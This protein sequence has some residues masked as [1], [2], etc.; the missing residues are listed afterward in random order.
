MTKLRVSRA[1]DKFAKR[2]SSTLK[3]EMWEGIDDNTEHL[4]FFGLYNERDYEV[5]ENFEGKKSIIWGG[6]DIRRAV[7]DYE[8]QRILKNN[9]ADH[10]CENEVEAKDLERLGFKPTIIPTF[11]DNIHNYPIT[12][13]GSKNPNLFMCVNENRE[14]EYG[15]NFIKSIADKVP[16]ARFHIYGISEG[17]TFFKTAVRVVNPDNFTDLKYKMDAD[18]PNIFYHGHLPEQEFNNEIL[19]YQSGLR[20]NLHDGNSEVAM[21]SI[22]SGGYPITRIKYP[23]IWSYSNE[24]ELIGL[25]NKLALMTE[26]NLKARSSWVKRLNNFPFNKRNYNE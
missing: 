23:D 21:K 14:E 24:E 20:P 10:Y 15:V 16:F 5:F 17:A 25:I 19:K 13:K 26:P 3:I 18:N 2:A 12:Y 6:S 22:L 11:M 8:R 7:V 4:V 9:P 1:I